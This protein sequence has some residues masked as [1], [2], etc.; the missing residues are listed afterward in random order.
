MA[1]IP[2]HFLVIPPSRFASLAKA[3]A[4]PDLTAPIAKSLQNLTIE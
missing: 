4:L 2:T 1:H 3:L